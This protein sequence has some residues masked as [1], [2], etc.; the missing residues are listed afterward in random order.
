[1]F[2]IVNVP[3]PFLTFLYS[4]CEN[5]LE[6][7]QQDRTAQVPKIRIFLESCYLPDS[8]QTVRCKYK[9]RYYCLNRCPAL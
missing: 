7:Q 1:M 9:A 2:T 8:D 3:F 6:E 5:T 4:E